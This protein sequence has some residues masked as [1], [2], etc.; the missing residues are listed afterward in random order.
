MKNDTDAIL[1]DLLPRWHYWSK[2]TAQRAGMPGKAPVFG[3]SASNSQYDWENNVEND[4]I[5]Q[6]I[7]RG[8]D[9]AINKV[10]QPWFTALTFQARNLCTG[11]NVWISPRLPQGEALEVLLLEART[12]LLRELTKDGVVC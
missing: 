3:Q 10:P 4:A 11:R 7:M 9:S 12:R 1:D 2:H 5:E 6:R 8:F